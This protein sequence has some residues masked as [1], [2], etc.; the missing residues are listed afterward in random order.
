MGASTQTAQTPPAP[1]DKPLETIW[2]PF[3]I[4]KLDLDDLM[5]ALRL[6][7]ADFKAMPSHLI[8]IAT[9]YP[10]GAFL[11][12]D[13][14]ISNRLLPYFFPL[15]SGFAIIGPFAAVGL[16]EISRRRGMGQKPRWSDVFGILKAPGRG[17]MLMVAFA[18]FLIFA[19]WM[20]AAHV[21]YGLT[22]GSFNPETITAFLKVVFMTKAGW[23]LIILGHGA[24]FV[25]AGLAFAISVISFPLLLDRPVSAA[26]AIRASVMTVRTNPVTMALWAGIIAGALMLGSAFLFIGLVLVLPILAH[27]SWHLYRRAVAWA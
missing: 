16:Y 19:A 11:L 4:R 7:F 10:L 24:G 8:F 22:M 20:A 12:A 25:F 2:A 14:S 17:A 3:T 6:G 27:A 26:D 15:V 23:M 18:L 1:A 21:I 5:T 9:I 13:L